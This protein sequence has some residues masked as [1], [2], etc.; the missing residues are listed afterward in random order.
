MR[1]V[2]PAILAAAALLAS[3]APA[4]AHS[5]GLHGAGLAE[6]AAH[7]FG[8][9]DHLLAMVAV[10]LWAA[11][12][13]GRAVWLVPAS[14]VTT[15]CLGAL[16]GLGG[17]GLPLVETGIVLSLLLVGGM[18][19]WGR[20]LP[21]GGAM[22]LVGIFA[23][24]HGHAHGAEM[25]EAGS[26]LAYGLGFV[27]ATAVLHGVGVAIGL[28]LRGTDGARLVRGGGAAVAA[29]GLAMLIG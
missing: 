6:G 14:F 24:F 8:G 10:G 4:A 2:R 17:V 11:Q 21:L 22:A 19:A 29:V 3:A 5:V 27:A 28:G 16:L 18:V 13:G 12:S 26:A 1:H 23:L 20:A 15:M 7:P 25:P 9:L